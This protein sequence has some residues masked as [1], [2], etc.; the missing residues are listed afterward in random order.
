VLVPFGISHAVQYQVTPVE[1]VVQLLNK[2]VEQVQDEGAK[3]AAQYDKYACF[4]KE[5]ADNKVY[6]IAKSDGEISFLNAS[7]TDLE[8][9]ITALDAAVV[10]A[11]TKITAERTEAA[12]KQ[13]VRDTAVSK[14]LAERADLVEA[15]DAV[16]QALAEVQAMKQGVAQTDIKLLEVAKK[17]ITKLKTWGLPK[18]DLLQELQ[19][20]ADYKYSSD[21]IIG[22]LLE[23]SRTFKAQLKQ[24]DED[25]AGKSHDFAMVEAAR[26]NKIAAFQNEVDKKTL[27]SAEK[28]ATKSEQ[29]TQLTEETAARQAD[30]AFLDSM[31]AAC[32]DKA[33]LWDQRSKTRASELTALTEAKSLLSSA[34]DLY[35]T[36]AKLVGLQ[37]PSL[38][39]LQMRHR[40]N[41]VKQ[42][43]QF[44]TAHAKLLKTS[45]FDKLLAQLVSGQDHFERVRQLIK[46]LITRLTDH[47]TAEATQKSWCDTEMKNAIGSR[48]GQATKMEE[49]SSKIE[50]TRAQI[51]QFKS[52]VDQLSQEIAQAHKAV[53]EM[54]ELRN[55]EQAQN[56]RIVADSKKGKEL[57]DQAIVILNK[58][59]T[60]FLQAPVMDR[61]GNT[62][63][64]LAPATFTGEYKGNLDASKGI[65]GML[66]VIA[67]DF[68]RTNQQTTTAESDAQ[69]SFGTEKGNLEAEIT[70]KGSEK[71]TKESDIKSKEADLTGFQDDLNTAKTIHS[72]ALFELEKLKPACVEGGETYAQRRAQREKEIQSL[73]EALQ[74]LEEWQG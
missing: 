57:I 63:D 6:S 42:V 71:S 48:D 65:I 64:D 24:L 17:S 72:Q 45:S 52:E 37:K 28:S 61:A 49:S 13:S 22:L 8:G 32:E 55:Q 2:L 54:T 58:F 66:E 44:L 31:R 74:I 33:K 69:S 62:V 34:G 46:D 1:K 51:L 9:K 4:C 18:L 15:V 67:A 5:Q 7:I 11:K 12:D 53:A 16:D 21:D 39:F 3:E 43:V 59:Y 19:Q 73:K 40:G 56:N 25:E 14:H 70:Q 41:G 68:D 35:G 23:L 38:S 10:D 30:Q 20:P 29:D 60:G 50:V 36:N 47:A 26:L 27:S